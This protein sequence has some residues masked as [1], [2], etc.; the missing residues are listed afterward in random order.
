MK[1]FIFSVL[2]VSAVFVSCNTELDINSDPDLLNPDNAPLSSQLPAGIIGVVGSEGAG[3]AIFGG[4]W[5]QYFTQSNAANQFKE[6]ENYTAG[7]AD[8]NFIWDG[9]YD[10]LGDI[11]NVK[12]KA[13]AAENWKYYLIATALEVQA[14][15]VL[16]DMYGSIP[17]KEANIKTITSP[18]FD[19]GEEIYGFMIDDLNDALSRDLST[20]KGDAPGA[21]DLIYGGNMTSWKKFAN[22]IKLKVYMRQTNSSRAAI[23]D[24]GIQ[25]M[26]TDGVAFLD[27][28]ASMVQF[29]DEINQSN[30]LY[31]YVIRRLNVATNLRMSRTMSSFLD[32]NSDPRKGSYY[33]AGNPLN[34]GD[35]NNPI[36]AGTIAT[37]KL[38]ATTPVLL[39]SKEESLFLQAEAMERYNSGNGAKALYDAA[40]N[41]N[42]TRF[43]LDGSTFVSG[44]YLYPV[45]GT[46]DQKLEAIITQKWAAGFPGNGFEAFF[47]INRTGYPRTSTV[48]QSDGAYV[49][50]QITYSVTGSTGGLFPKRIV[51]PLS[52]RNA[53]TNAPTLELIT[54]PVWWD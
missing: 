38:S 34:Q 50:G 52:E 14:S 32:V 19:T 9:M 8:Y 47:E 24:A 23:A 26:I 30:P 18:R 2:M 35:F 28:D 15:Q 53:N 6:I 45:A 36:G 43:G 25:Q 17:Y 29:V 54:T 41:A 51:Y 27:T 20:S 21:D 44:A 42:F 10:A 37:I 49:P 4:I 33:N 13:L 7:T 31:E 39:M 12:R 5:S 1:K 46:F 22:T 3:M 16:T 40:V 48:P 11:R